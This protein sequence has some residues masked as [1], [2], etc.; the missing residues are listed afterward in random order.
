MA[1]EHPSKTSQMIMTMVLAEI[2]AEGKTLENL[3]PDEIRDKINRAVDDLKFAKDV[4][5]NRGI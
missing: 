2:Q 3:T 5:R 4:V 1:Q